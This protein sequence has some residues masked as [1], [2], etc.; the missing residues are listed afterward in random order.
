MTVAE[1]LGILGNKVV[2][3]RVSRETKQEIELRGSYLLVII[4]YT[5]NT[6]GISLAKVGITL[7]LTSYI[8]VN[9]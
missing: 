3:R 1:V 5:P 7:T 6:S 9:E 4:G 8:T 2:L